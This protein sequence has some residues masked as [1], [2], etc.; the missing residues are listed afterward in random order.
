MRHAVETGRFDLD[1]LWAIPAGGDLLSGDGRFTAGH[2]R[3][4]E[5]LVQSGAL[6]D[7]VPID[8]LDQD[9]PLEDDR[10]VDMA[11]RLLAGLLPELPM[12]A[13][14]GF[15]H[16]SREPFEGVEPMFVHLERPLPGLANGALE[17]P[18]RR[19]DRPVDAFF[20][21]P[22]ATPAVVPARS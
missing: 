1:E 17:S 22:R 3:V 12:L 5:H 2:V 9:P 18:E 20:R 13:V 7:V 8:R 10:E 6:M 19:V 16:A 21:L 15:F 11:D 4:L 14:V